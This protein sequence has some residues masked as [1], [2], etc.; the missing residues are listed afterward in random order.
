[1]IVMDIY[2]KIRLMFL[3]TCRLLLADLPYFVVDT[4]VL[5]AA[6]NTARLTRADSQ[7]CFICSALVALLYSLNIN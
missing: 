4:L 7:I 6:A 3:T 1:M 2:A 5:S